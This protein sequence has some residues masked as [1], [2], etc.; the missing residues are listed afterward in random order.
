MENDKLKEIY[1]HICET[2]LKS[3]DASY[4]KALT[5]ALINIEAIRDRR[6]ERR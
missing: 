4:I 2:I 5:E 3:T 6:S 1:D